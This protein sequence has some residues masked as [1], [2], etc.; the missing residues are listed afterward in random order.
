[1][2]ALT[3]QFQ[4]FFATQNQQNQNPYDLGDEVPGVMIFGRCPDRDVG[5]LFVIKL[6]RGKMTRECR[7]QICIVRCMNFTVVFSQKNSLIGCILLNMLW[8]LKGF[9]IR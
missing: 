9:L 2:E 1:M 8:S 7:S 5:L 6:I 4:T 3:Q